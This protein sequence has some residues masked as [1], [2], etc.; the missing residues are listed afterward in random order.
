MHYASRSE[1]VFA[2][3]LWMLVQDVQ[4][5][6]VLSIITAPELGISA[7]VLESSKPLLYARRQVERAMA[8]IASH[9]GGWPVV[10]DDNKPGS[11]IIRETSVLPSRS[12]T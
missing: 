4:P 3:V 1:L 5:G 10:T 8:V 6:H 11:Q 2:C 7:H 9:N 12:S